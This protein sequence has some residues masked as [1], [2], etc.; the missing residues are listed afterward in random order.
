M[1]KLV[2][3]IFFTMTVAMNQ[4]FAQD[5][6]QH[7]PMLPDSVQVEKMLTELT[8]ELSLSD[9]QQEQIREIQLIHFKKAKEMME[10]NRAEHEQKRDAMEQSRKEFEKKILSVLTAEQQEKFIR[11]TETHRPPHQGEPHPHPQKE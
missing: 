11:F 7:P 5:R 6:P 10:Q 9:S 8:Q 3:I 2:V 1:K 4:G